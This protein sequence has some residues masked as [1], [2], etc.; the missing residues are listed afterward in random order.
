M[1]VNSDLHH[2]V[3]EQDPYP[4]Q[5]RKKSDPDQRERSDPDQ[6]ERSNP[7]QGFATVVGT[8]NYGGGGGALGEFN[9]EPQRLR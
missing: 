6:S 2:F 3:E 4:E 5:H 9:D 7:D 8:K 1:P